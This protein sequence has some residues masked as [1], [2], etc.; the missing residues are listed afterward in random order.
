MTVQDRIRTEEIPMHTTT[1]RAVRLRRGSAAL[2]A[3]LATVAVL[4]AGCGGSGASGG[5]A[6]SG[7]TAAAKAFLKSAGG[8]VKF[9][10]PGGPVDISA[11]KGKTIWAVTLDN[12]VPFSQSVLTAMQQA[13]RRAGVNVKIF[14]GKGS[15]NTAAQ[16]IQQAVGAH[17]AAIVAF[18][19]NFDLARN[20]IAAAKQ[21]GIPV[22]G[23]LNVPLGAKL[24]PGAAGE[25]TIDYEKSGKMLAAWAI[26]HTKGPVNAA[27]Q[28]LPSIATFAGMRR[29]VEAG[30]K[31]FCPSNC[32]LSVN[33]LTQAEFKT[34]AQ[35]LTASQIARTPDLN[36]V[37][38]AIDALAQF[39]IPGIESAGKSKSVRVG[40][41][42]AFKSNLEYIRDDRVQA[43]DVGNNNSW[44]GWAMLDRA[45]RAIAGEPPAFSEVPV[46]LFDGSTI[47]G[48]NLADEDALFDNVPY[49]DDYAKL[50]KG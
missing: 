23:A 38:P 19:V 16:G 39:T 15:A 24:E 27:Y 26:A 47:R 17:A 25:V 40:S 34:A 28:N 13:G 35:R 10:S 37:F 49:R 29:G 6:K 3:V 9:I 5:A 8:P 7:D 46:K 43:V 21:A 1:S 2:P 32:K 41:I 20:A 44:L 14:D 11:A 4:L 50:W 30:F 31:D 36:W 33:D 18:A 48:K 22:V 45:L 12:S 42:N